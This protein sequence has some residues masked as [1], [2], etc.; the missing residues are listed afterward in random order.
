MVAIGAP[1]GSTRLEPDVQETPG[2]GLLHRNKINDYQG[3]FGNESHHA[4]C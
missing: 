1:S 4:M 3:R 2:K